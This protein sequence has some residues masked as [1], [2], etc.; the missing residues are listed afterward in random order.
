MKTD[1]VLD[2]LEKAFH[3]RQDKAGQ[4]YQGAA[5]TAAETEE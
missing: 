1:L 3:E 5:W 4:L 2:A